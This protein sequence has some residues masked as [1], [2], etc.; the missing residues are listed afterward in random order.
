MF[1]LSST[2]L[3]FSQL[4]WLTAIPGSAAQLRQ[5]SGPRT[6]ALHLSDLPRGSDRESARFIGNAVAAKRDHVP[7]S[8]YNRHGRIISYFDN[9]S[10]PLINGLSL[11]ARVNIVAASSEVTEFRTTSGARWYFMRLLR[12]TLRS[13]V[14]GSTT[15]GTHVGEAK[16]LFPYHRAPAP[17]VGNQTAAFRASWAAD[18]F[19]YITRSIEFRRGRYVVFLRVDG[20]ESSLPRSAVA[21]LARVIDHRIQI[22]A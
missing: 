2:L 18:E 20:I 13:G 15:A 8:L 3:L 4:L 6:Y 14:Y 5:T 7:V 9:F 16:H 12:A 17:V 10:R 11:H 19:A 21:A 1:K 22:H